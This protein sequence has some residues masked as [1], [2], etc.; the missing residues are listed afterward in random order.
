M[1]RNNKSNTITIIPY[2]KK[3]LEDHC[4]TEFEIKNLEFQFDIIMNKSCG[5]K[6]RITAYKVLASLWKGFVKVA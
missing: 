5:F 1:N 2:K 3:I 4:K 6:P